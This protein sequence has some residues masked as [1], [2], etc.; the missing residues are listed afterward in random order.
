MRGLLS[1][2]LLLVGTV[3]VL[4]I[5]CGSDGGGITADTLPEIEVAPSS[6]VFPAST[7]GATQTLQVS[8]KNVGTAELVIDRVY[9][10]DEGTPFTLACCF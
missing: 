4:A 8:I 5:G 3:A 10:R 7:P 9:L 1:S 6:L 2:A